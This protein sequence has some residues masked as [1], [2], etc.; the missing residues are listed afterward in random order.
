MYL[1]MK[2]GFLPNAGAW[3]DQPIKFS[4]AMTFVEGYVEKLRK[5]KENAER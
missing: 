2:R 1:A 4:E 3:L 5:E